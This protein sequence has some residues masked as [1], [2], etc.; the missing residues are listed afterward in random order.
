MNKKSIV[1]MLMVFV[2]MFSMV[3]VFAQQ[4]KY[5]TS[6][7]YNEQ[8]LMQVQNSFQNRYHFN[9]SGNCTYKEENNQ[10]QLEVKNQVRVFNLFNLESKETYHL[11]EQ[12]EILKVKRNLWSRLF[13]RN[14][15]EV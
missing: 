9:C 11:S 3:S 15:L 5:V 7:K 2:L 10:L 8:K 13:N 1:S 6:N 4:N 12:G 14:V